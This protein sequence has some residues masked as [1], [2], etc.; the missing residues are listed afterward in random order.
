MKWTLHLL[1]K[2]SF[3]YGFDFSVDNILWEKNPQEGRGLRFRSFRERK[4]RELVTGDPQSRI[5]K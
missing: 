4:L 5:T 2:H 3:A 1:Q